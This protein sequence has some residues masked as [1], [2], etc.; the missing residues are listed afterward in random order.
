MFRRKAHSICYR[1]LKKIWAVRHFS[2][3]TPESKEKWSSK[4]VRKTFLD[5]FCSRYDHKFVTS[6]SVIPSKG[7]GTY[8]TNSGMNQFKPLFLGTA[9]P[10]TEMASYRRVANSQ[11]CVRVGGKHNDLE[12]V[13]RDLTHHTFFEMLGS[14]SFGD[15]FKKDACAMA[16][17]L[18]REVYRLPVD[19][20]YFT[21]FGGDPDLG[22]KPDLECRNIWR[23]L[24]IPENRILPFGSSDNFWDMGDAG[25]CGPCTEI[26]YDH[27]GNRDASK[28]VNAGSPDVIE[29]WNLVFMEYDRQSDRSL[30]PLPQQH[31]DTG[32][33]LERMC[34]VLAGTKSN[35]STDLFIPVFRVIQKETGAPI[36]Q[37]LTGSADIGGIN[38]AYRMV[39]DHARMFT[40]CISDGLLPGK[41]DLGS[42]LR[43]VMHRCIQQYR[44]VLK[45]PPGHL[46]KLVDPVVESLGE[47]FPE[48]S[49]NSQ[50]IKDAVQLTEDRYMQTVEEGRKALD[51]MMKKKGDLTYLTAEAMID[52]RQGKYGNLTMSEDVIQQIAGERNLQLN[53]EGYYSLL[54]AQVVSIDSQEQEETTKVTLSHA[55]LQELSRQRIS[56]TDDSLKYMYTRNS[57][58]YEFGSYPPCQSVFLVSEEG[59][60]VETVAS[61]ATCGVILD[62]TPFYAEGGGQVPDTGFIITESGRLEVTDV[63]K[64]KGYV[65]HIGTMM[66][67]KIKKNQE[68]KTRIDKERRLSCMRNHTA[69]HILN[70]ALRQIIGEDVRQLGSYVGP[71]KFSFDFSC[72]RNLSRSDVEE[73]DVLVK[74][75]ILAGQNVDKR[76]VP[77]QEALKTDGIV[78]LADE[79]YPEEVNVITIGKT[80][81]SCYS[82]EL[83]GG[84]H[85]L[86][87]GDL[88]EFCISKVSGVAQGTKR[89]I[90]HTGQY[91]TQAYAS[92]SQILHMYKELQKEVQNGQNLAG[93]EILSKKINQSLSN[94]L[95]PKLLREDILNKMVAIGESISKVQ[96]KANFGIAQ[97]NI[98]EL[99]E[100][101]E[102]KFI[103]ENV[104]FKTP[105]QAKKLMSKLQITKPV[106]IVSDLEGKMTAL[107][108]APKESANELEKVCETL[109]TALG[110]HKRVVIDGPPNVI[111]YI[112]TGH[113]RHLKTFT[114]ES[115]RLLESI[116]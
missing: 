13:G 55:V 10:F 77:L 85:V 60:P 20:L 116:T 30:R 89:V 38:T 54:N 110:S 67:G 58:G 81:K 87:T 69:T 80:P 108:S 8:F 66:D 37:D 83:C 7:Q 50:K 39:A 51:K 113:R 72:L 57:S 90:G 61:G 71:D 91:A 93:I 92:G 111:Q 45:A 52:L 47:S 76:T 86:N 4:D 36:Y 101:A 98:T 105:L 82:S 42:K 16:L 12:D 79:V 114:E 40:V 84:T 11:K 33:G 31:V 19:R 62:K 32:M 65:L 99:M 96:N 78:Y 109:S 29:I 63:Q 15:Y 115:K 17:E 28:L 26:H 104:R 48:L 24:G 56:Y 97:K 34:A 25:P 102:C 22:L 49:K 88:V 73:L 68:V 59:Q 44:E 21:Y 64:Y 75:T 35:Y 100:N 5:F 46:V 18:L 2:K 74:N 43:S 14:W 112:M 107:V 1:C 3:K 95:L 9:P 53:W 27:I 23:S 70:A 6:S 41:G 94:D 106:V 103:I